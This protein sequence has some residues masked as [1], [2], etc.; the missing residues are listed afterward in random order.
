MN[1][2]FIQKG[3]G[4]VGDQGVIQ[5]DLGVF[6]VTDTQ[7][8][9]KVIL[10]IGYMKKGSLQLGSHI[11]LI[12]D[13][14]R[15]AIA[16]NHSATH[17]LHA[18][19]RQ[20][21]GEHVLQKG[22]L[23]NS[24]RLR[25][26]FTHPKPLDLNTLHLIESMVNSEIRRNHSKVVQHM[27]LEDAKSEGVMALFDEKYDETV[28][29]MGFG[30]FSRELCGGLHVN[31]TGEIG[32][33][34][35]ISETGIASGVRRIE[36]LTGEAAVSYLH[37]LA[38]ERE[39]CLNILKSDSSVFR[40]KIAA[41]VKQ[42]KASRKQYQQLL[43]KYYASQAKDW[44]ASAQVV[45]EQSI[46]IQSLE[47]DD[48]QSLRSIMDAARSLVTKGVIVL[49]GE[50]SSHQFFV[51]IATQNA[52]Y[53][54]NDLFKHLMTSFEGSGGGKPN[55]AQG[56]LNISSLPQFKEHVLAWIQ[57]SG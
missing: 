41:V 42:E 1:Q 27:S 19:L 34:V 39:E 32:Y 47:T 31:A 38:V 9:G 7:K 23:V 40:E 53:H 13:D 30:A 2:F 3:G 54:A 12:V 43:K 8:Q 44:V 15:I 25:F 14:Q 46:V 4:Q 35:I 33:F 56:K 11:E 20:V 48:V 55:F 18:A 26:D 28:R 50:Q 6:E 57:S 51:L 45:G 5:S 10:H 22:S 24:E 16:R 49:L 21:L 17:L 29:V 37:L 52:G 36:A